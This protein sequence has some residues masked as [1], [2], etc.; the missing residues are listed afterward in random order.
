MSPVTLQFYRYEHGHRKLRKSAAAMVSTTQTFS[1]YSRATSVPYSGRW[2]VRARHK[3]GS[4][5]HYS[6]YRSFTAS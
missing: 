5:Y 1:K 3:V 2:R 6:G 4:H